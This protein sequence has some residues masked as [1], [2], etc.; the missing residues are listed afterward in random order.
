MGSWFLIYRKTLYISPL[1][2]LEIRHLGCCERRGSYL[3]SFSII[4]CERTDICWRYAAL[5][6]FKWPYSAQYPFSLLF[7]FLVCTI[8][9]VTNTH[10]I[11]KSVPLKCCVCLYVPLAG[12]VLNSAPTVWN[13]F[14]PQIHSF[15]SVPHIGVTAPVSIHMRGRNFVGSAVANLSAGR[16]RN[17]R[18]NFREG[19]IFFYICCSQRNET[20]HTLRYMLTLSTYWTDTTTASTCRLYIRPPYRTS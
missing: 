2:S 6:A 7:F 9:S 8:E 5:N 11:K 19:K 1:L 17:R 18:S 4:L 13:R 10:E 14:S 3:H 15:S 12:V 16:L 20:R